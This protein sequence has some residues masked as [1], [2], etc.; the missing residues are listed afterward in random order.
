M[1]S[2]HAPPTEIMLIL[3][4]QKLGIDA[5]IKGPDGSFKM[6]E[7]IINDAKTNSTLSLSRNSKDLLD[8]FRTLGNF[9]AHKIE[10]ICRRGYIQ[11]HIMSY[12]GIITELLHK[13]GIK[14]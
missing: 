13:S 1:C 10:Y 14:I 6:L 7:G 5:A 9:S 2:A 8:E 11:P 12:R 3:S 4:Y